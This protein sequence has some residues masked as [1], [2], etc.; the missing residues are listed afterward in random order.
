MKPRSIAIVAVV[1]IVLIS[2]WYAFR[3]DRLFLNTTV[4]E[5]MPAA[6]SSG[7]QT[8]ARGM[9]HTVLHPTDGSAAIYLGADGTRIL[10][11]TNFRTSNGPDVH[12]YLVA[13]ENPTDNNSVK[14]AATIDLGELKGNIGDQNYD[15]GSSV[16]LSTYRSVV[17]W[18]RR[19]SFNFGYAPL[20]PAQTP[21]SR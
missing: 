5:Q 13:V 17:V 3:P 9:F 14:N 18:C 7:E 6:F 21:Q 19:F 10:R 11:F 8:L 15:V 1:L 20:S 4:N 12:I 2:I 16:D